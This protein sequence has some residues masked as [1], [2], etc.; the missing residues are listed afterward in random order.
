[1]RY[2]TWNQRV[3][4]GVLDDSDSDHGLFWVSGLMSSIDWT[5]C[6]I[7]LPGSALAEGTKLPLFYRWGRP[8]AIEETR[9]EI[10][11]L[12]G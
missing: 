6:H 9:T 7:R 10:C 4:I 5:I 1:M 2:W 3:Y 12:S 8:S 11:V